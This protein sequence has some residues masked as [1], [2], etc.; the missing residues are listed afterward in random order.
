MENEPINS[1][2]RTAEMTAIRQKLLERREE[3]RID[4]QLTQTLTTF[5]SSFSSF[6]TIVARATKK[7][8]EERRERIGGTKWKS[9]PLWGE[10]GEGEESP[11]IPVNSSEVELTWLVWCRGGR[12]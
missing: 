2:H 1:V 4:L 7:K 3:K 10:G 12:G 6:F 9:S 11:R 8:V 5:V